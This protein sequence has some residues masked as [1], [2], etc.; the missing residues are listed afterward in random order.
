MLIPQSEFFW[1][2]D[3]DPQQHLR[4]IEAMEQKLR[5]SGIRIPPGSRLDMYREGIRAMAAPKTAKR[6]PSP[7][8]TLHTLT[9]I[10][11]L[12]LILRELPRDPEVQGWRDKVAAI[13]GGNVFSSAD[14]TDS[15]SRDTQF[16]LYLAAAFRTAGFE[17][18]LEEPDV[19]F[20]MEGHTIGIA[21]KRLKSEKKLEQRIREASKQIAGSAYPGIIAI[22]ISYLWDLQKPVFATQIEA[23][24]GLGIALA[25]GFVYENVPR[26]VNGHWLTGDSTF[27]LLVCVNTRVTMLEKLKT[28]SGSEE[29]AL[30]P[31]VGFRWTMAT[32]CRHDHKLAALIP[33]V[34]ERLAK[35]EI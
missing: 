25:D 5:V 3:G 19:T 11:E 28:I 1:Q 34:A 18:A 4:R 8:A 33:A 7:R 2:Q 27:G 31:I 29:T 16:E 9:E 20:P 24:H 35:V 17:V 26:I 32:L 12:A 15:S 6:Y 10:R 23:V 13:L 22:D 21:A 30:K 14:R